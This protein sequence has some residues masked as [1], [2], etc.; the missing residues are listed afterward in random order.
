MPS[1]QRRATHLITDHCAFRDS[2][3]NLRL[4]KPYAGSLKL[5]AYFRAPARSDRLSCMFVHS[6]AQRDEAIA[7]LLIKVGARIRNAI[8]DLREPRN[9][10]KAAAAAFRGLRFCI[11]VV[12]AYST[13]I[14]IADC[15]D[16]QPRSARSI[17]P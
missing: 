10:A 1:S 15:N 7:C 11:T 17:G 12:L 13:T 2:T 14:I 6:L 3:V 16:V 5:H 9:G 8:G 4:S